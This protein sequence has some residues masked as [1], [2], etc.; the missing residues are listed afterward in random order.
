M[1]A[2][3]LV[4]AGVTRQAQMVRDGEVSPRELV[5]AC[6]DRIEALDP[7]LNAWRIVLAEKALAEAEQAEGRRG[8]GDDR[9]LLGV[10]LAIKDDVRM[11]GTT[12]AWGTSAHGPEVA[13]DAVIVQRLREAGAI[14][15]GKTSVPEMTIWPFTE[16]KTFGPT[17]NPWDSSRTTGG[18]SGGTGAAV[19][20]GMVG[21]GTGS[22]GGGSIRIPAGWCGLF[23]LKATRDRVP[24]APHVDAWRGL[25]V[26]GFLTRSVEDTALLLDAVAERRPDRPFREEVRAPERKLRIAW[27]VKRLP[28]AAPFPKLDAD[29]RRGLDET[30]ELLRSLGHEVYERD[31]DYGWGSFPQFLGRY[32]KGIQDDVDSME[33]P[34]RLEKRT[35]GMRRMGSLWR[36]STVARLRRAE[37]KLRERMW[38]SIDA[39]D[40][41]MTPTLATP[42]PPIGKW[43]GKGAFRTLNGVAGHVPWT[44]IFNATGQPAANVPAGLSSAGTP[45]GVQLVAQMDDEA[46]LLSLA[47]QLEAER[48]WADRRPPVS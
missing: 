38:A 30:A 27:S 6:L 36:E 26:N 14:L 47:A 35:L 5:Q 8:A 45:I 15:I 22:D 39:P 23:G 18:S 46:T 41:F 11:A 44:A 2:A 31:P 12:T 9:P 48:P 3:D 10:P 25:S 17:R 19:A 42:P 4:F 37:P 16:S 7:R 43:E 20:S 13:D 33:H 29:W 1:D 24:I 32:L 28:G 21:A 40:V 34:E